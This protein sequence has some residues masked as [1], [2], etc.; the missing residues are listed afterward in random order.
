MKYIGNKTRLLEFIYGAVI[1]SK[2]PN[3]GTFIDLFSGTGSV[4]QYFKNKGYKI[5]SNDFMH[6]SYIAQHVLIKQNIMPSF[7]KLSSSG[8]ED[9]LKELNNI[10][11]VMGYIFDNF[12]PGGSAA[13]QYFS[14]TN[15]MKIDAIRD[16]IEN[17]KHCDL[18]NEDEYYTLVNSLIDAADFVANISGTYGAYLKIWRSM[19]LKDI[20]LL[21]P[22]IT[23]NNFDNRVYQE[24]ANELV[25]KIKGD[26][27]YLDPPYNQ[28]QYASNFHVLETLAVWDKQQLYG[29]TGQRD[30]SSKKS[31]YSQ[32]TRAT[33]AFEDLV[34]NINANYIILSYNNEGIIP[35]ED[36]LRILNNVG[37]IKE[38]TSDYRR[39]RTE[40]DH[41][42]RHYKPFGD[43]VL[44]HLFVVT[45]HNKT[46]ED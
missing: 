15:A 3:S 37:N 39:F 4:G 36:I 34:N 33:T 21:P 5:I 28:R 14:D 2:L 13:R 23:D 42:K 29:K 8:I 41:E 24:D 46:K 32:K 40:R 1:D 7:S 9:V 20:N 16:R 6:Y 17:W 27:I 25:K 26:I 18:L 45:L 10:K 44:E 30:Y 19:A 43:K 12:A 22:T 31:P 38:Y 35:R 11:P